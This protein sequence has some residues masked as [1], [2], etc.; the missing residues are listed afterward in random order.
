MIITNG[1]PVILY[2]YKAHS[3]DINGDFCKRCK[4]VRH[5]NGAEFLLTSALYDPIQSVIFTFALLGVVL[6]MYEDNKWHNVI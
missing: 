3:E 1:L 5:E 2:F 6:Q 4:R